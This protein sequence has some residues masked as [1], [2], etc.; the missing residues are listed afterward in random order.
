[1]KRTILIVL[2][3]ATLMV[4]PA[5]AAPVFESGTP[6]AQPAPAQPE[7]PTAAISLSVPYTQN[8]NSLANTGTSNAWADDSTL[9]GWYSTRTTYRADN[10]S[11]NTGAL[12]SFGAPSTTERAL[13]SIASGSTATIYYGVRLHNDT[14]SSV[15]T[16]T[17]SYT[18]EQWRNGGNTTQ[19]KLAFYYQV[20][21]TVTSLTAGTWTPVS[22]LDF[23]GPIATATASALD[24]NAAANRIAIS[25]V[26]P[27]VIPSNQ[28]IMLRWEDINDAGNDHGLAVDDLSLSATF[29]ANSPIVPTCP[30]RLYTVGGRTTSGPISAIDSDGTV[31]SAAVTSGGAPGIS[32]TGVT[33]AGSVGGTLTGALS[34]GTTTA[35]GVYNV[36]ITFQN[37][38]AIPQT[39]TCTVPV[40]VF[41]PVCSTTG[42]T[43]IPQIQGNG[44]ASPIVDSIV[45]IVGTVV[46]DFQGPDAF[47]GF[48]VQDSG[49]GDPLTS[50]GIFV[51]APGALDVQAGDGV[52]VTGKVAE[53]N[54]L[55]ELGNVSALALCDAP[56]AISP[57]PVTLPEAV[58][59]DLERYEDMLVAFPQTLTADQNYFQGRYG[60]I[61]LSSD[62]R[63][64][65]PTNGNGLGDTVELNARR[66]LILDDG[67][68]LQN[69]NPIPYIGAD[70][71]QRAGDTVAGLTGVLDYG[72]INSSSPA[73]YDYRVQP[74]QPVVFIR[75]NNRTAA[76]DPVGGNVK[77]ASMNTLNY[78]TTIDTGAYI[79]GPSHDME[80]RGADSAAELQRQR[81][82][83]VAALSA[84][85]AD[86][87]GLMELENT[88]D[89]ATADLVASLN[90]AM[91]AGTYAY[92]IPPAPGTDAIRVELI[93]KPARVTPVG[94]P[95]NYQTSTPAY[96]PL[97]DRP[98]LAQTFSLNANGEKFSIVVNHLKS[99]SSCPTVVGDP[100]Q[101]YGQGCW[102]AKRTAQAQGLLNFIATLKV[103][104]PDVLVVGDLNAYGAE[105]PVVALE[106]GG[107]VNE[108][109][110]VPAVSR[111]TYIFDGQSGSLDHALTTP[112]LDLQTSGATIWHINADEPSVID[113]NLEFKP[114]DLYT[115]TPYR[116]TDHDPAVVGFTLAPYIE[117]AVAGW[118][119]IDTNG[120]GIRQDSEQPGLANIP[121]T[122]SQ[123][124]AA[125]GQTSTVGPDGWYAFNGVAP[126]AYCVDSIIPAPWVPTGP[127][128]VCVTKIAG[129]PA[130]VNFGV[131][132][133]RATI[134]DFVWYDANANGV[135]DP[136]EAGIPGV[137]LAL[138][139]AAGGAPGAVVANTATGPD[140][141]YKFDPVVPGSYFVQVT[142][143][144]GILAG[145][146]LTSGPQSKPNPFGPITVVDGATYSDADFGYVLGCEP[147]KGTIAGMVFIDPNGNGTP[148]P[149]EQ[150]L[151]GIQVCAEP[152]SY[153]PTRCGL[154]NPLGIYMMCVPAGTYLIAP[155]NPPAGMSPT[156]QFSLPFVVRAGQQ[157]ILNFGYKP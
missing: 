148:D 2:L 80:C 134:G 103:T 98:P 84:I 58:N 87:V 66:I 15:S 50:D 73:A 128:H 62:G 139:T 109:N 70:N 126:G 13:G 115:P 131:R 64:F 100:D 124:G 1:M 76:P 153:L 122:L 47:N 155:M 108:E 46:G 142:D 55:T 127:T 11:S 14:S 28:E 141:H 97:F 61:T 83:L 48:N 121:V 19:Q 29:S 95:Q 18:G 123:G 3:L 9:S 10:G 96:D 125:L 135:Q 4:P 22:Q 31:V 69:P 151:G 17:I 33:P 81:A 54:G 6:G 53:F 101:E 44:A 52:R 67:L 71:T 149:G 8:F 91:G 147:E 157:Q 82:K 117:R 79:C 77:V 20:G 133:G 105:D 102:N 59:N 113:Y 40:T 129:Q 110:R 24:G 86:V 38:D 140:G 60:Q 78:F 72:P 137:T 152:L 130:I 85:D 68:T 35:P 27:V 74:T 111:Y 99:K 88:D 65:N 114:Q 39:A 138:W 132:M 41:D 154:T 36:V 120:D 37:N 92:V 94:A 156:Q 56:Y 143:T 118:V 7:A 146:T 150:G 21:A 90:A 144:A 49:D 136:G 26:F 63:M 5:F 45:T 119:F 116:A 106:A 23:T 30:A 112:S 57:T 51:Y 93:Y 34:I 12:Y 43:P 25:Y 104:D 107:M 75:V 145:L 89:V 42:I 32:L 16:I